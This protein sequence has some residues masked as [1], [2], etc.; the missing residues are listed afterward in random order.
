M[1]RKN[2]RN[3]P[4]RHTT[5]TPGSP[6]HFQGGPGGPPAASAHA[7]PP[8]AA[9]PPAT[10]PAEPDGLHAQLAEVA[11]ALPAL[12][13]AVE[14]SETAAQAASASMAGLATR[15]E[16][17]ERHTAALGPSFE[18]RFKELAA[19]ERFAAMAGRI[20]AIEA[21][22]QRIGMAAPQAIANEFHSAVVSNE[23]LTAYL[24]AGA[25]KNEMVRFALPRLPQGRHAGVT[26]DQNFL[27]DLSQD[28]FRTGIIT[29]LQ[30]P[31]GLVDVLNVV[32]PIDSDTYKF[33]RWTSASQVGAVATQLRSTLDG[34]PTPKSSI[35]VDTVVGFFVGQNIFVHTAA[36]KQ[37]P[38][39]VTGVVATPGSESLTFATDE[40]DFDGAIG[41]T[42]TSEEYEATAESAE[43]P[44]GL[45]E[46]EELSADLKLLATYAIVTRQRL[47][48][49]N[50]T[51]LASAL[52][53]ELRKRN[54]DVRE[55]HFLLGDNST[56]QLQGLRNISGIATDV[57]SGLDPGQTRASLVLSAAANI[58]GM[59]RVVAVM[60]K[61]DWFLLTNAV[62]SDGHYVETGAGPTRIID[63]PGLK[64]VGAVQ[65]VISRFQSL[66]TGTIFA[67]ET[68]EAV[69]GP[70]SELQIGFINDQL[71]R[72]K[73]TWLYEEDWAHAI[74]DESGTRKFTFDS[75]PT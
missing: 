38:E 73:W 65:V 33:Y 63:T 70:I 12:T 46:A 4:G 74:L 10:P 24:A 17:V 55:F 59:P 6:G 26:L 48:R 22:G 72:N 44:A 68:T 36:G 75:A 1:S 56:N 53:A 40:I 71:I 60:N 34:D 47:Q 19:G 2:K 28:F 9:P 42:V 49:T 43:K 30:D 11:G 15:V 21:N 3:Q 62:A 29:L 14:A 54:R 69:P 64:A 37:G 23:E 52:E 13:T 51:N 27:G 16:A 20:D 57:W 61:R 7:A 45:L 41:D 50:R 18:E 67:P 5:P 8:A 66:T 58:P 35:D 31:I 32:P 25:R 39:V